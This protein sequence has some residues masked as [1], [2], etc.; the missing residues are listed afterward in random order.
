MNVE[1]DILFIVHKGAPFVGDH[2]NDDSLLRGVPF[3][4]AISSATHLCPRIYESIKADGLAEFECYPLLSIIISAATW[5]TACGG[6]SLQK[7][8]EIS[9]WSAG[10]RRLMPRSRLAAVVATR[11]TASNGMTRSWRSISTDKLV[12]VSANR[13]VSTRSP[14]VSTKI[15]GSGGF[16]SIRS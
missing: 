9:L 11:S 3:Y 14:L 15:A 16:P 6:F 5:A 4:N 2:A 7:L 12:S 1:A 10:I 13:C 8:T